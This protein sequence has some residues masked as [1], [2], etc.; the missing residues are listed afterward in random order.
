MAPTLGAKS[1]RISL[2]ADLPLIIRSNQFRRCL[3]SFC[4]SQ[5]GR[6]AKP[7]LAFPLQKNQ[8]ATPLPYCLYFARAGTSCSYCGSACYCCCARYKAF[9]VPVFEKPLKS[10]AWRFGWLVLPVESVAAVTDEPVFCYVLVVAVTAHYPAAADLRRGIPSRWRRSHR[11][12][13]LMPS[14]RASSVSVM[15]SWCSSTKC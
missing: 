7:H 4:C 2:V 10:M 12:L 14:L 5:P 15:W 13:R 6:G 3:C 9:A 11:H 1:K 8:L